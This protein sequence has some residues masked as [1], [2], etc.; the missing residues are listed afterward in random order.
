[1]KNF[2]HLTSRPEPDERLFKSEVVDSFIEKNSTNIKDEEIRRMFEQCLP[3]TLDTTVYYK[4]INGKPDSFI[5]T[6]DIP[7]MWLRDSANQVWPYLRFINEDAQIQN[8]FAGL[9]NRQ[10]K[11]IAK[12]QYANA[13]NED[14]GVWE[15]K[16]ELDSLCAFLRL[17]GGYYNATL[18]S[19]PFDGNWVTAVNRILMT[20][21]LEQNTLNKNNLDL[22]FQFKT[23]SGHLHPAVRLSGYGYP[24]KRCGLSR[25]VF[26]P[27]DDEA[28]FPYIIPVNAMAV[29]ALRSILSLLESISAFE[30]ANLAA[31]LAA[32]INSGILEWGIIEHKK[33]GKVYAYEV[34]A[35]VIAPAGEADPS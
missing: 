15:R 11:C 21:F 12:D 24:G 13:F 35:E 25:S 19:S 20:I 6:G 27:S 4:E 33:F 30:T 8:L 22:L 1:M 28:V 9:I 29:V 26:R 23:P 17:S 7:A 3:N 32:E 34:E 5:V 16:Y 31:R 18:D 10:A 2:S 14:N